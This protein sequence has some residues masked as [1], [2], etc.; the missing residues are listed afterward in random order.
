MWRYWQSAGKW[1]LGRGSWQN[2]G[3]LQPTW[4]KVM[5]RSVLTQVEMGEMVELRVNFWSSSWS[6]KQDLL[7]APGNYGFFYSSTSVSQESSRYLSVCWAMGISRY[8]R[9]LTS[10]NSCL[11]RANYFPPGPWYLSGHPSCPAGCVAIGS[12]IVS[13]TLGSSSPSSTWDP[14]QSFLNLSTTSCWLTLF[15]SNINFSKVTISQP[16]GRTCMTRYR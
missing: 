2:A 5:A 13:L 12:H 7:M 14:E 10:R 11:S 4:E 16:K 15:P 6:L 9:P 3:V 8:D 1:T